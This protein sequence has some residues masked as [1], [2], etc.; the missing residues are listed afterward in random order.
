MLRNTMSAG[1]TGLKPLTAALKKMKI[2]FYKIIKYK[3]KIQIQN[4]TN[5]DRHKL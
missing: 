5:N 2:F 1:Q 4:T 3:N